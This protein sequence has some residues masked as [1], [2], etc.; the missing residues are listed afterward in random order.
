MLSG[1]MLIVVT[2]FA[3]LG[4]YYLTELLAQG[5]SRH[6]KMPGAVVVL[7]PGRGGDVWGDVLDV[8]GRLP[9]T[10]VVVLTAGACNLQGLEPSMKG[11][12]FATADTVAQ[13][14]CEQ[15]CIPRD[16]S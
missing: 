10:H 13:A 3:V 8:R 15:L 4:A 14:V 12:V 5:L 7:A 9:D 16:G 11:V 2:T 6:R 1:V